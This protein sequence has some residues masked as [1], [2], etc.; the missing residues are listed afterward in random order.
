MKFKPLT[1]LIFCSLS[2]SV[3]AQWLSLRSYGNSFKSCFAINADTFFVSAKNGYILRTL[4][5]GATW[6]SSKTLINST[7]YLDIFF[8]SKSIGYAC[9]GGVNSRNM[10]SIVKT[11][12]MG[13]TWDS[14]T[15]NLYGY[16]FNKLYFINDSIGYFAG[17]KLL[18]T[19]NGCRTLQNISL[20][21]LFNEID[22]IYFFNKDTGIV[23]TTLYVNSSKSIFR[24]VKTTDGGLNWLITFSDSNALSNDKFND[25]DFR[26]KLSGHVIRNNGEILST[27]DGGD[28]WLS[29]KPKDVI[30]ITDIWLSKKSQVGYF[31]CIIKDSIGTSGG[32]FKT[33]EG[34]KKWILNYKGYVGGKITMGTDNT[35]Y[36]IQS[37]QIIKTITGGGILDIKNIPFDTLHSLIYP[38]PND[39]HFTINIDKVNSILIYNSIGSLVYS[40]VNGLNEIDISN[41]PKG[42]YFIKVLSS[43]KLY[44]QKIL[45]R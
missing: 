40:S 32:I 45:I 43:D 2:F 15:S 13:K 11:I 33:I 23:T 28:T 34:G 39:G 19:S 44:T 37:G 25:I 27:F 38:N 1:V 16:D 31:T 4:D 26:D 20:P 8:P 42:L 18:K 22:A 14:I 21:F 41:F 5:G 12:N 9:G 7:V 29:S 6:D 3:N 36:A 17:E 10:S 35:G 30:S 24:I